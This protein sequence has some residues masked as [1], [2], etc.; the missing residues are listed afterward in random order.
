MPVI[1]LK[2]RRRRPV[3]IGQRPVTEDVMG[4][5]P[6]DWCCRCGM[7]IYVMGHTLCPGCMRKEIHNGKTVELPL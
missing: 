1:Y 5:I 6:E 3:W 7:E 4:R 2:S